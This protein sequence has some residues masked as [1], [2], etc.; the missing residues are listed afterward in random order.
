V[1]TVPVPAPRDPEY[2]PD[3]MPI[4]PWLGY[5][6]DAYLD[7]GNY[8]CLDTAHVYV[9]KVQAILSTADYSQV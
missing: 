9:R 2:L 7:V 4:M 8:G 5:A 6:H 1:G 3:C